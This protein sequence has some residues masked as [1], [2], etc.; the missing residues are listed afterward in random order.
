MEAAI[1]QYRQLKATQ[2][3]SYDFEN[4]N[5]DL[6]SLGDQLL[7]AKEFKE[8]IQILEL[9]T[10]MFPRWWWAYDS[11]GEAYMALGEKELAIKNFKKSLQPDPADQD[12]VVKLKQLNSE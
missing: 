6:N 4:H 8:A 3:D 10:E 1:R 9:N 5:R 2:P 12:A 11:L 7:D